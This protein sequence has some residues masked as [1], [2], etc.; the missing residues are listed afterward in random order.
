MKAYVECCKKIESV[1]ISKGLDG[2]EEVKLRQATLDFM[3]K[4]KEIIKKYQIDS[5]DFPREEMLKI[6]KILLIQ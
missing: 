5:M 1:N 3:K 4:G 6:E 2:H